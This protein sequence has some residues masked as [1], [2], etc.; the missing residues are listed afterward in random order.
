MGMPLPNTDWTVD[1]VNALPDDRNRYEVIDGELFVTPA[2]SLLH[3]RAVVKLLAI[4]APYVEALG[5]DLLVAPAAITFSKRREVQPDLLV[6]PR[7]A[8][9][10]ATRFEDV[11]VLM[12]AVEVLSPHTART[13]RTRKRT[14]YQDERVP[15]YWIVDPMARAIEHWHPDSVKAELLTTTLSWQPVTT[16]DA[17]VVDLVAYFHAVHGD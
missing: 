1:M 11:G 10:L 6:L 16:H 4:L 2:P 7:N 5:L 8:G 17:L 12:L 9:R 15:E 13:D 14:L 3:Q